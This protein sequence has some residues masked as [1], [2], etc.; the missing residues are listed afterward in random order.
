VGAAGL[1][2]AGLLSAAEVL[3]VPAYEFATVQTELYELTASASWKS[4]FRS[5][6]R[7]LFMTLDQLS[8]LCWS[9][10]ARAAEAKAWVLLGEAGQGKT[11][12]LVDATRRAL[13][14]GRP[15]VT[16]FG[17]LMAAE[18]PL[19]EIA[20][21]LG[22]G[23]VPHTVLLQALDAAAAASNTRFLLMIDAL[24]DAEDP[25]RW[26]SRLPQL[27][28]QTAPYDHVAVVVSCRS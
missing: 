11:H 10:G 15:A 9:D 28:A 18:D 21:Q 8:D 14:A 16:V 27:W 3:S 23:D 19:T 5:T 6:A 26:R 22:L 4:A 25:G 12:L 7:R 17:E 2:A 20:R 24:N 1:A 13:A